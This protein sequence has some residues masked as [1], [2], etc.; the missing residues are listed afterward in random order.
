MKIAIVAPPSEV[1][2]ANLTVPAIR[3]C[4]TGPRATTPIFCPTENPLRLALA[5][6]TAVGMAAAGVVALAVPSL[7]FAGP[8]LGASLLF[9][10]ALLTTT[11]V[12]SVRL[13]HREQQEE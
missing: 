7:P 2:V 9:A 12:A 4:W 1:A 8:A 11:L 6:A 5:V 13:A 3:N 10:A